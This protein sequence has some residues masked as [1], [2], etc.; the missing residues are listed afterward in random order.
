MGDATDKDFETVTT[1]EALHHLVDGLGA[2][3]LPAAERLLERLQATARAN[4]ANG[5]GAE[6]A[7]VSP[8]FG[9]HPTIEELAA[10]QGVRPIASIDSL[11]ATFW[12]EDEDPDAFVDTVRR[13][14]RED[15]DQDA[16]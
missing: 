1:R 16:A 13:W 5:V 10:E 12:P 11:R 8:V 9:R 4:S 15:A 2:E 14:R 7:A 6:P 3:M